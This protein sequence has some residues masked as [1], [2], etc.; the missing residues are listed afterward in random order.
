[1]KIKYAGSIYRYPFCNDFIAFIL[2]YVDLS[3]FWMRFTFLFSPFRP[4]GSGSA[5]GSWNDVYR[6]AALLKV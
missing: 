4:P 3:A 1:M 5:F 2:F 6:Y